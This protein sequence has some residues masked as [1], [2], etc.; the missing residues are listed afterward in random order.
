MDGDWRSR[1]EVKVETTT[2]PEFLD[3]YPPPSGVTLIRPG[4][5]RW[6]TGGQDRMYG[7]GRGA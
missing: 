1:L 4:Q 5:D 6:P 2:G 7:V 3:M